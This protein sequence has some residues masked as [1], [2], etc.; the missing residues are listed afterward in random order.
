[1][2]M[3]PRIS[4]AIFAAFLSPIFCQEELKEQPGKERF[5]PRGGLLLGD[6]TS[7]VTWVSLHWLS[8]VQAVWG[9]AEPSPGTQNQPN[10]LAKLLPLWVQLPAHTSP[11]LSLKELLCELWGMS[12][13]RHQAVSWETF[14]LNP[15]SPVSQKQSRW[16]KKNAFRKKKVSWS[17][18][19]K[20]R[21]Q[22]RHLIAWS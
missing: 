21:P 2:E 15:G 5:A 16:G 20:K 13:V 12:H 1:M 19:R 10:T 22:S 4:S 7:G 6:L 9:R 17:E 18:R 8:M 3:D 14:R 11:H